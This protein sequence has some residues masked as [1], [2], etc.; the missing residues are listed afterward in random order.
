MDNKM[1]NTDKKVA[2]IIPALDPDTRLMPYVTRLLDE[3]FERIILIDDGSKDKSNFDT[4]GMT[5]EYQNKVVRLTHYINLGKGR[6][7]KNAFNYFMNMSDAD[8][9]C[10]AITVDSDGQHSVEDTVNIRKTLE[11]DDRSLILGM[12]DFDSENVPFKSRNGNRITRNVFRLLHGVKLNDTQTGLRAFPKSII[13]YFIDLAGERFEYE[14]NMLIFSARNYIPIKEIPIQTIYENNNSGTHFNPIR[15]SFAIYKLLFGTFFK[16]A[17]SSMFSFVIDILFFRLGLTILASIGVE[18]AGKILYATIAARII[19]SI[20]NFLMN[21]NVV[22]KS[23]EKTWITLIKYYALCIVQMG[24]SAGLVYLIFS[25]LPIP[26]TVIKIV[27][28]AF[29]FIISFNIQKRF[30]FKSK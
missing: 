15:D 25:V 21:R 11:E 1:Q 20:C 24:A 23:S 2:I 5:P 4:S 12:R 14:T 16:Y 3:G 8:E 28:D 18:E 10:G 29:L 7:L 22:F 13:P 6:A 26:E 17:L 19:S 9:Y 30:I 27:V